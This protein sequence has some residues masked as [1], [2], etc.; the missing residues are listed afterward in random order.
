MIPE[1]IPR[2]MPHDNVEPY[3]TGA[4]QGSAAIR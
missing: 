3:R 2:K 4:L 1:T